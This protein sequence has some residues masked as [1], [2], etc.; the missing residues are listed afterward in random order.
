MVTTVQSTKLKPGYKQ[1]E[2][3]DIPDDWEVQ[4]LEQL[5]TFK[6]G[7]NK[8]K[9]DFGHGFPFVN[10]LDVFG[11]IKVSNNSGFGLV[12]A[13]DTERKT[14]SLK[15]GDVLFVRSSVKPEGVGLTTLVAEDLQDTVYSGFLI[16]FRDKGE[17]AFEFKEHCFAQF[18]FR[19]RLIANSTVSANTNINQ[20]ALKN[21]QIAFPP[22]KAEQQAI[23][24]ALSDVETLITSFDKLIAKKHA[25]KQATM[26]QLL[27]GKTRL[28]GFD[29]HGSATLGD[30]FEL[31]HSKTSLNETDLVTFIRM[32]DV[33]ASGSL[34]NQNIMPFSSIKKGYTFFERND[35]LIAKITPCFENGKGACLDTMATQ[36]GFGSTEFHVLRAKKNAVPRYIFYQ[37]QTVAFRRRLEAEMLGTAGQKRVPAKAII[38]YS[39]PALH[40]KDEQQAIADILTDMDAEI[41]ALQ[42]KR[43]KYRAVKQGMMQELLTGKTRLIRSEHRMTLLL[44]VLHARLVGVSREWQ[45]QSPFADAAAQLRPGSSQ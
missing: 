24:T 26:Q 37:T 38:D 40:T 33:S 27:T 45:H 41:T 8:E 3:G 25:I 35:V 6:N 42:R 22:S 43:D 17:L 13:T 1:T 36:A 18:G 30:F 12:N 31:N 23:A 44:S 14:Y 16:R 19:N 9:T 32:E 11:V 5:G 21:L 4:T 29:G 39:L 20:N 2:A 15:K 7:I 10:L 34:S 28:P